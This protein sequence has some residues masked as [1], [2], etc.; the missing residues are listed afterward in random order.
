MGVAALLFREP[1][2]RIDRRPGEDAAAG[3]RITIVEAAL[4]LPLG[5]V[6][7]GVEFAAVAEIDAEV[8]E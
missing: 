1:G 7:K 8:A 6:A 4:H 2:S 3:V 5:P